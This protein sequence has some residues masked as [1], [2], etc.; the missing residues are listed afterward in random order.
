MREPDLWNNFL[1]RASHVREIGTASCHLPELMLLRSI[2]KH[3]GQST[4]LPNLQ[5][6]GWRSGITTDTT[7]LSLVSPALRDLELD[8]TV[9]TTITTIGGEQLIRPA[10]PDSALQFT[11]LFAGLAEAAP[12]LT[13]LI[14]TGRHVT[15]SI[16]LPAL[17]GLDRLCELSLHGQIDVSPEELTI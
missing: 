3:N 6:I 9:F 1:R 16:V 10:H 7:L 11:G 2:I 13:H 4:F 17:T 15:S 12:F 8:V 14:I 5:K